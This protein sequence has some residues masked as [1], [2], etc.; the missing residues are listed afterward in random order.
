MNLAGLSTG[1]I[2]T[3]WVPG[4]VVS[5][6]FESGIGVSEVAKFDVLG[7]F[8]ALQTSSASGKK[9]RPISRPADWLSQAL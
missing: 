1:L 7:R 5:S 6:D 8:D 4:M 3:R 2:G 9:N